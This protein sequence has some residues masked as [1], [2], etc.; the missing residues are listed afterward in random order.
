LGA[1]TPSS[2]FQ[3]SPGLT[4][5]PHIVSLNR[6]LRDYAEKNA[7]IYVD[8]YGPLQDGKLGIKDGLS[9]DGLHPNRHGFEVMTPL[10]HDAIARALR[11]RD[12][13]P[14][15]PRPSRVSEIVRGSE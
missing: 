8:Y 1:I 12:H 6:W 15:L 2:F 10:A 4:P 7:L 5:G 3:G 14:S 13:G 11:N 9:N